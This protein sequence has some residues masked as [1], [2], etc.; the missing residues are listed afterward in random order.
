MSSTYYNI[1]KIKV[2]TQTPDTFCETEGIA[3]IDILKLDVKGAELY[4][5]NG[6][7]R[8]LT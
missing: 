4:V 3:D 1:S 7:T 2:E 8:K 6:V 5:L